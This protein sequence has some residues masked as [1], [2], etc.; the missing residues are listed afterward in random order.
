MA[1]APPAGDA[2]WHTVT[3]RV[4]FQ[5][6]EHARI[7]LQVVQV[8]RELQPRAVKRDLAL[9]GAVLVVTFTTL[10]VRLARLTLNAFLDNLD[11]VIRTLSEFGDAAAATP[12]KPDR[13]PAPAPA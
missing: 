5:S 2:P 1:P 6:A 8:D 10:T 9:D 13:A 12:P 3:L 4:P 11:L 7:A